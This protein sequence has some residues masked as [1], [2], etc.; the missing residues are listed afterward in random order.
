[1]RVLM[2]ADGWLFG[3]PQD[4]HL[5]EPEQIEQLHEAVSRVDA[6][7][8]RN[9]ER[10]AITAGLIQ[11][12]PKDTGRGEMVRSHFPRLRRGKQPR[13]LGTFTVVEDLPQ[14]HV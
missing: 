10:Q 12:P 9:F 3:F 11:A 8:L 4:P 13:P 6:L 5:L 2:L 14:L 1:V 7:R